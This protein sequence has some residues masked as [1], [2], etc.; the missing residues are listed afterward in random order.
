MR[1]SAEG[2]AISACDG[3]PGMGPKTSDARVVSRHVPEARD[4][5]QVLLRS[6]L[7]EKLSE[8]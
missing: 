3:W 6:M 1:R 4:D 2:A 8:V 7:L 5:L